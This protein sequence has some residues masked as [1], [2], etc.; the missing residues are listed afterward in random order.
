MIGLID[1]TATIDPKTPPDAL[2][3]CIHCG[4]A[5]VEEIEY[6]DHGACEVVAYER[7]VFCKKAQP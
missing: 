1:V 7:C 2:G 5:G 3:I 6:F 4:L